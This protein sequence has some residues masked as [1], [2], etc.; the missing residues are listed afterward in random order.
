MRIPQRV[1]RFLN[2][3]A[4]TYNYAGAKNLRALVFPVITIT[5]VTIRAFAPN[6]QQKQPEG[7]YIDP[8]GPHG[9]IFFDFE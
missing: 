4:N 1:P 3:F 8:K 2:T 7:T 6:V 5:F 9:P